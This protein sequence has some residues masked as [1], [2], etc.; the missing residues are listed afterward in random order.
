MAADN[1][2][3]NGM[4]PPPPPEML[5]PARSERQLLPSSSPSS[6]FKNLLLIDSRVQ[7]YGYIISS[8]NN[9]TGYIV[10]DYFIDTF[11][12]LK[13]KIAEQTSPEFE[14]VG[15]VQD[16]YELPTYQ[17]LNSAQP[18]ILTNVEIED[19]S[20]ESWNETKDFCI[21]LQST[22][23]TKNYDLLACNTYSN[24][25]W[26]YV[27]NNL[28]THSGIEIRAS[29]DITG[30]GGNWILESDN[31]DLTNVYFT[32]MIKEW[33]FTLGT[34]FSNI[35]LTQATL[36]SYT[37]PITIGAAGVIVK[38]A[39]NLT[40]TDINQYFIINDRP[41]ITIDGSGNTVT[42]NNIADY[43]GL[44]GSSGNINS[45]TVQNIGVLATGSATLAQA[46]G[47]IG[48]Q[49]FRGAYYVLIQNCYSNGNITTYSGGILGN[50]ENYGSGGIII[51]NCY[52][53]GSIGTNAGG[54]VG[55]G[56]AR[57]VND[58]VSIINC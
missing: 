31:V 29:S 27:I 50:T 4:L 41:N 7:Q 24:P 54:I 47:W 44:V 20:L 2:D 46:G 49:D 58:D 15:I 19:G 42:I 6:S 45:I 38:F 57:G 8:L 33:Q 26:V 35:T 53:T 16:N 34:I 5:D 11:E 43:K 39:E 25:N 52:S 21:F 37:W 55:Y 14:S 17:L 12:T 18:S 40:F 3:S 13:N 30:W 9:D 10:F 28:E 56:V 32:E 36:S 48:R 1:V 23:Q 22:K 51:Q